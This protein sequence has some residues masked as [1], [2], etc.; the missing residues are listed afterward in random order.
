MIPRFFVCSLHACATALSFA[1]NLPP[2]VLVRTS[3]IILIQIPPSFLMS[4]ESST[5]IT[6][7]S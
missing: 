7:V 2:Y 6:M 5:I 1:K 3:Q 4:A